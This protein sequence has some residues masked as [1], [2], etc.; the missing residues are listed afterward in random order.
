[1]WQ[2]LLLIASLFIFGCGETTPSST[3]NT[4]FQPEE[5]IIIQPSNPPFIQFQ[6]SNIGE[7]DDF[8]REDEVEMPSTPIPQPPNIF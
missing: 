1:M 2:S 5:Y 8:G 3:P 7:V 4:K 6:D